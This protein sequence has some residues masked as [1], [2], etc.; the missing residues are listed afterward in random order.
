MFKGQL[1]ID[2]KDFKKLPE[3]LAMFWFICP[4]NRFYEPLLNPPQYRLSFLSV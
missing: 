1:E 3:Q 2:I 4:K